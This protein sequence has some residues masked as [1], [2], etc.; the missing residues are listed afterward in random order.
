MFPRGESHFVG[1]LLDQW[2]AVTPSGRKFREAM[3][4]RVRL[5]VDELE[6]A[7]PPTGVR[8]RVMPSLPQRLVNLTV[9]GGKHLWAGLPE[10]PA[11]VQEHRQALCSSCPE[12]LPDSAAC[13]K[14]GCYVRIKV[15]WAD[16]VCPLGKWGEWK[17]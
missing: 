12:Y 8:L 9:A 10:A 6:A 11:A 4:K 1:L 13:A 3:A 15:Q 5:N 16:S 14:C 17:T 7:Y 2:N